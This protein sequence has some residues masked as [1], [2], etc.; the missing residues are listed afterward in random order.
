MTHG[1]PVNRRQSVVA[2]VKW[3]ARWWW[4]L[5]QNP[6]YRR[7]KGEWGRPNPYFD[8]I[9][10]FLP[11][12]II[13]AIFLGVCGGLNHP[14][15]MGFDESLV[16]LSC[17]ACLPRFLTT[18][19]TLTGV[20]MAPALTAPTISQELDKGTW[21]I[22]RLTPQPTAAILLAKLFGALARMRLWLILLAL[23]LF[24][25]LILFTGMILTD[26]FRRGIFVSLALLVQPWLELLFA[27]FLGMFVSTWLRSATTALAASYAILVLV[28]IFNGTWLWFLL[29]L[30][31]D[32]HNTLQW[33]NLWGL[34]L[35]PTAVYLLAVFFL[36]GGLWW[37]AERMYAA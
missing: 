1:H 29:L 11:F 36:G 13:G 17:L 37:R 24:Q 4:T 23:T 2:T 21:D 6:I 15:M 34:L 18:A 8:T 12:V 7:E 30:V 5:R 9:S 3:W 32:R 22:L 33:D 20:F 16:I 28:R 26:S 14:A 35:A 19:V 27:G 25:A 31:L 10:R